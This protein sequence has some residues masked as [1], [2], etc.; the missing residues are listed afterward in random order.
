[1][2]RRLTGFLLLVALWQGP[3]ASAFSLLGPI[4]GRYQVLALNYNAFNNDIGG[5]MNLGEEYRWNLPVISY[6]FDQSFLEYFG[7]DGVTAIEGAFSILN[8]LTNMSSLSADLSEFPIE[9][10]QRLNQRAAALFILDLK[11]T[12]LAYLLELLGVNNSVRYVWTLRDRRPVPGSPAFQYLVV[13]RNFD[14]VTLQYSSFV[15][16]TIYSYKLVQVA[17]NPDVFDAQE[18]PVDPVV[19]LFRTPVSAG[20]GSP[21]AS[22]LSGL[23]S[24]MYYTGLTRDDVGALRHIYRRP[25]VNIENL[26]AGAAV[27]TLTPGFG[28]GGS[29]TGSPWDAPFFVTNNFL[30]NVTG[31]AT[32]FLVTN[33]VTLVDPALHPGVDK[34]QFVKVEPDSGF[35][36]FRPFTNVFY[37]T[38]VTNGALFQQ[39]VERVITNPDIIF[40]ADDLGLTTGGYPV[41]IQRGVQ[42]DNNSGI[43]SATAAGAGPGT[44][45]PAASIAFSKLG[46]FVIHIDAPPLLTGTD[47][48]GQAL[49]LFSGSISS[50]WGSFDG[51]TNAPV[52]YPTGSSLEALERVHLGQF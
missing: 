18:I 34:L 26:L 4:D 3:E 35:G 15:N 17:A 24:G 38:Y 51:T 13:Q 42:F 52:I 33:A 43:N 29:T 19:A 11:S 8:A 1:M 7:Q 25:N 16:D 45:F 2:L 14:P 48:D 22:T 23:S 21:T 6:G 46:P 41:R 40:R 30:T 9:G 37:N 28:I 44:L 49:G 27:S 10:V 39:K 31:G 36:L 5:P 32:N 20:M 50:V 12:T 47:I